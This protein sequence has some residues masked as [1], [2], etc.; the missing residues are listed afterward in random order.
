MLFPARAGQGEEERFPGAFP[1]AGA[2]QLHLQPV[3]ANSPLRWRSPPFAAG[4]P[5]NGLGA[6]ARLQGWTGATP[7]WG[8]PPPPKKSDGDRRPLGLAGVVDLHVPSCGLDSGACFLLLLGMHWT[9]QEKMV[10]HPCKNFTQIFSEH[11]LCVSFCLGIRW[12]F[13]VC[14]VFLLLLLLVGWFFCGLHTLLRFKLQH[15]HWL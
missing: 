4:A 3:G 2:G 6:P 10:P 13:F 8:P 11:L 9:S 15:C 14:L 1:L 5:A 7:G 12:G